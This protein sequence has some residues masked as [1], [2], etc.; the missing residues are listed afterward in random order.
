MDP[1]LLRP[2]CE[3]DIPH[4]VS[5]WAGSFGDSEELTS[6]LINGRALYRHAVV[7]EADGR[8]VGC[9]FAFDGLR[10]GG[11]NASY[12]YALCTRPD[13]R[14]LGIGSAV[15]KYAAAEAFRRGAGL[16]LLR[17]A[18][19]GLAAWHEALGFVPLYCAENAPLPPAPPA[20]A[21]V[22]EISAGEYLSRR[23]ACLGVTEE[24]IR[25]QETL[26]RFCGGAFLE[27]GGCLLCAEF[28]GRSVLIREA[29]RTGPELARIA[30]A[31]VRYFGAGR[32]LLRRRA[33]SPGRAD[34]LSVMTSDGS[35]FSDGG[36]LF[37]P[38]TL[39]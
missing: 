2:A 24:L 25:A 4:M 35:A 5:I 1:F 18:D 34:V 12:L 21:A 22:R 30:A 9:M 23:G 33:A 31:A 16:T 32:A 7:A 38:F 20:A 15:A 29:D 3:R 19:A 36:E 6:A 11:R 10:F 39:E 14:G 37:F 27:V 26:F 17:P 8:A 13:R 28:D